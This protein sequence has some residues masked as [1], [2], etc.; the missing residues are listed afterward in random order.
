[1]YGT[2]AQLQSMAVQFLMFESSGDPRC[3]Q[4]KDRMSAQHGFPHHVT[5]M[6]IHEL[7]MGQTRAAA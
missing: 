4:L 2:G 3:Q 7:A 6:K 1:M 5:T